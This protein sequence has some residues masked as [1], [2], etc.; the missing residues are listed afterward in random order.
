LTTPTAGS[1]DDPA[2]TAAIRRYEE[3]RAR[4]PGSLVFATLADLYRKVGRLAEAAALCREGL[5]RYPQYTTARLILARTL[6]DAG[7]NE[8]AFAELNAISAS[9]PKDGQCRRLLAEAERRRGDVDAAIR[10]LETAVALD[11]GD[12]EASAMLGLLTTNAGDSAATGIAR[13]LR[14][15]VFVT[16]TFGGICLEQGLIEEAATIFTRLLRRDPTNR[17]AREGLEHAL[18]GRSGRKRA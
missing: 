5:E 13:T 4:D 18:R 8:A 11:P 10:H 1:Y 9:S 15:D 12:R 3:R 7:D 17:P 2:V 6:L 16:A 14:D